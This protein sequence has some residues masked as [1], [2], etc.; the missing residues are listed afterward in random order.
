MKYI[1]PFVSGLYGEERRVFDTVDDVAIPATALSAHEI[2][3]KGGVEIQLGR[4][5]M[6]APAIGT[7]I[8][9]DNTHP[10]FYP[11]A[12][13][14]ADFEVNF[15]AGGGYIGTGYSYWAFTDSDRRA[16]AILLGF[17]VPIVK[18]EDGRGKVLFVGEGRYFVQDHNFMN[19]Y[20]YWGGIRWVIR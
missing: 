7:S 3:I 18:H 14:F 17:G 10:A 1:G 4:H 2:G 16:N 13:M 6:M 8:R 15:T 19:N 11:D 9:V 20:Q 5:F 12:D